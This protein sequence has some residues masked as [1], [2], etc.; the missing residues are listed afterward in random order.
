ME[1]G[2]PKQTEDEVAAAALSA[3]DKGKYLITTQFLGHAMRASALG[4]SPR[5]NWVV[6]TVFSWVTSL[7][8]LFVG[9]DMERKAW[10][11]GKKNG[12]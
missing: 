1:D 4:G 8:W 7:V 11:Y 12:C 2:D 9:P 6:D 3:L 5:D 10:N